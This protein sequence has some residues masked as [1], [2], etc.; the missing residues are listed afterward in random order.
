MPSFQ[1][2]PRTFVQTAMRYTMLNW[3]WIS[4]MPH[5]ARAGNVQKSLRSVRNRWSDSE[6]EAG[7]KI[8]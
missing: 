6:A 5:G 1:V 8:R 7:A 3:I 4:R 2:V